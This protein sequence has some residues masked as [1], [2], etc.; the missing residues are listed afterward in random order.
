M[1]VFVYTFITSHIGVLVTSIYL[2]RYLIHKQF[3]LHPVL[4]HIFRFLLWFTEGLQSK[5]FTAQH[6]KHHKYSDVQG[7]PHSPVLNGFWNVTVSC[8]IPNFFLKYRYFDTDWAL[9]HYGAGTPEDWLEYNVYCH[10]RIG[11][12]LLLVLNITLFGWIGIISW[13]IHMFAVT[14]F[15][16][17]NITGLG[18]WIGY[19]NYNL[20]DNTRNVLPWGIL[21]CGEEMH[22]N[23]HGDQR[24][25]NFARRWF[26]FDLGYQYIKLLHVLGLVKYKK[27]E[28]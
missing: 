9:E 2:H 16:N 14:L 27:I 6:R 10:H 22:N 8:L 17:A 25:P 15:V 26:E 20:V 23:H 21:G 24:N 12:L 19:R 7:D 3:D 18:H 13:L 1:N 4:V 28:K 11:V 5:T